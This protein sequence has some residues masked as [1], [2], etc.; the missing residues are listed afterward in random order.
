MKDR[1]SL[2]EI[3]QSLDSSLPR[4][5]KYL[6][7]EKFLKEL[8][9][10]ENKLI[11]ID[12]S[13]RILSSD[14]SAIAIPF[15]LETLPKSVLY[16]VLADLRRATTTD[17]KVLILS[18]T[19]PETLGEKFHYWW[20]QISPIEIHHFISP[21]DWVIEKEEEGFLASKRFSLLTLQRLP[22]L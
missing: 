4:E 10:P 7:E 6:G 16:M 20:N 17:G 15:F 2:I 3:W 9:I 8:K 22:E 13:G 18:L 5:I 1:Q 21:E 11:F 12:P 14:E 19:K